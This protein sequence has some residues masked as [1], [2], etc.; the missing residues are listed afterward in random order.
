M[1][2]N[3]SGNLFVFVCFTIMLYRPSLL[4]SE[5]YAILLCTLLK[6]RTRGEVSLVEYFQIK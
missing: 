5:Q 4:F 3:I 1:N 2:V 6:I